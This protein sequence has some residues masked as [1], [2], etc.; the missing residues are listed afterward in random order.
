MITILQLAHFFLYLIIESL[1]KSLISFHILKI[2][3]TESIMNNSFV[4]IELSTNK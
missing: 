4:I 1:Q 2:L 3:S